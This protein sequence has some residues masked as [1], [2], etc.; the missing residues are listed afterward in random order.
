MTFFRKMIQ[1]F[2]KIPQVMGAYVLLLLGCNVYMFQL[3]RAFLNDAEVSGAKCSDP[4]NFIGDVRIICFLFFVFWFFISYEYFRKLKES[5]IEEVLVSVGVRKGLVYTNQVLVLISAIGVLVA[6]ITVYVLIGY[7]KLKFPELLVGPMLQMLFIDCLLLSIASSFVGILVSRIRA[8]LGA[9]IILAVMI[10]FNMPDYFQLLLEQVGGNVDFLCEMKKFISILPPDISETYDALY[11]LPFEW[12]RISGM[13][14]WIL[15]GSIWMVYKSFHGKRMF[16]RMICGVYV[17]VL[18][19]LV[20]GITNRGSVLLMNET[21]REVNMYYNM[22]EGQE[23]EAGY[24]ITAYDMELSVNNE[25]D[26]ICKVKIEAPSEM[27]EY[28]FT[29][30]HGYKIKEVRNQNGTAVSFEQ[31]GDY[32]QIMGEKAQ[33]EEEF[34][35]VY[36][37][38]SNLFYANNERCFLAGVFPFYPQAGWRP[39]FDDQCKLIPYHTAPVSFSVKMD[40]P[41]ELV[42]NLTYKDGR[43]T[44]MTNSLLFVSGNIDKAEQ[45]E[46]KICYPLQKSSY[47]CVS[48][49]KS[50]D[51]QKEWKAQMEFLGTPQVQYRIPEKKAVVCIPNSTNFMSLAYGYYETDSYV[52]VNIGCGVYSEIKEQLFAGQSTPLMEAF[53][54]L[55][56]TQDSDVEFYT[57]Y[58]DI[59]GE[60]SSDYQEKYQIND[61]MVEKMKEKGVQEIASKVFQ[62]LLSESYQGD[63]AK[64]IEFVRGL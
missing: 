24:E 8:R 47:Q 6:N 29:L 2:I 23:E 11:G 32:V 44:G 12:Y 55:E 61:L 21:I 27:N 40:Y 31:N 9:Y 54:E 18:I 3:L 15:S 60:D 52:L 36:E 4:I 53:L 59:Y 33:T 45:K 28:K 42:S 35:F 46:Q 1:F 43:W 64:D 22:H 62:Y 48:R 51:F 34:T 63:T 19:I 56:P 16:Q 41:N 50:D 26:A 49:Y 37:G 10:L 17:G 5:D 30:Y 25:L 14:L 58:K 7:V 39:L 57:I 13:L 20:L 38:S